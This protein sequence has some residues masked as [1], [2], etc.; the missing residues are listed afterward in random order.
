MF[1]DALNAR[2]AAREGL[3]DAFFERLPERYKKARQPDAIHRASTPGKSHR[4]KCT[5]LKLLRHSRTSSA[6]R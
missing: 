1:R 5:R 2:C 3:T 6:K 4:T